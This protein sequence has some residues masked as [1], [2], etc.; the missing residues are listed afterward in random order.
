M[1]INEF[2]D[3]EQW[4]TQQWES[5]DLGDARR[6]DRA[7]E[8]GAKIAANPSA[9]LPEQMESWSAL[10]AAYRLF[11]EEDVTH[12]QLSQPHW[13]T[14]RTQARLARSSVVLFV[15]D[16]TELDYSQRKDIEGLGHIGDG[17]GKGML[18][19]PLCGGIAQPR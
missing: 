19:L 16:T 15:Q 11:N 9:S 2:T 12:S 5:A 1:K 8:I 7:I 18:L 17:K 4:A 10:K 14:T 3:L 13:Q 6:N